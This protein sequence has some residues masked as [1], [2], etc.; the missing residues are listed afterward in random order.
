L[1]KNFEIWD[2]VFPL[3]PILLIKALV[4]T[5]VLYSSQNME[6]NLEKF[7]LANKESNGE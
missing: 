2:K 7:F 5:P 4:I 6:I 1:I 3:C